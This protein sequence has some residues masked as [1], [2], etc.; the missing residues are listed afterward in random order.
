MAQAHHN[1]FAIESQIE[2]MRIGHLATVICLKPSCARAAISH[3]FDGLRHTSLAG[4]VALGGW[5]VKWAAGVW[6]TEARSGA[7]ITKHEG[8]EDLRRGA[9]LRDLRASRLS[10]AFVA[11][12]SKSPPPPSPQVAGA[13]LASEVSGATLTRNSAPNTSA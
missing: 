4:I 7:K 12:R 6:N 2:V 13:P 11:S 10:S 5:G 1:I 3:S 9:G 8:R